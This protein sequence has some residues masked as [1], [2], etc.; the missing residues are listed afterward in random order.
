M[1]EQ[2]HLQ[3]YELTLTTQGLLYV[4]SG[5]K[6]PRKEYIF[7]A[8]KQT[9]AFLNEQA[10]F[11]LLIQ[12]QLV[13]LFEG[14]CM[15]QGGDLYTFL[16]RECGLNAAQV[17]PAVLYEVDASSAMDAEHTLKDID[18]FMRNANQQAYV[19]GSSVKGAIRTALLF[20]AIQKDPAHHDFIDYK[21]GIPEEA[22]FHTLNLNSRKREDA[23]NSLMRGIQISDS[24]P[25]DDRN[26][27]LTL[28]TDSTV[29]GQSHS[30][31]LCRECVAPGTRIRFALT[32]DQSILKGRWTADS[33]LKAISAFAAYQMQL[34]A[35]KFQQPQDSVQIAGENLLMLGGGV[36]FFSKSL[37]YPYLGEGEGLT[38][39][40]NQLSR[41]FRNHH[42]ERDRAL[43][44]SPR[45]LKYGRY[46]QK[47]YA[48]GACKVTIQ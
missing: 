36:G 25:I 15:R 11:D 14:Y 12:N 42:H 30:I 32:L 18:C 17:N 5:K 16:Y 43:G 29:I 34:Y 48:Y 21:K 47:L 35:A 38:W 28:K 4:G 8:R 20:D 41:A 27:M 6:L 24:L 33:I 40:V 2:D 26:M 10:F 39:T 46:R 9:V 3:A 7:N 13:E 44:V 1:I 45:T 31:N 22:Y 19:P 23:V 37:V